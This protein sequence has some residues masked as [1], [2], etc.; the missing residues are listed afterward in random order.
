MDSTLIKEIFGNEELTASQLS[1][2]WRTLAWCESHPDKIARQDSKFLKRD[3]TLG[4][5][6][7]A[8]VQIYGKG[9]D[10]FFKSGRE[11]KNVDI[12]NMVMAIYFERARTTKLEMGR[13]FGKNHSTV[14]HGIR[15]A[16]T[17]AEVD[18]EYKMTFNKLKEQVEICEK[19]F[20]SSSP[21][22]SSRESC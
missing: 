7:A 9:I 2:V 20:T 17:L 15:Q 19:Q 6:D 12:R 11:R 10:F 5:I 21:R 14:I 8:L 4:I 13:I 16:Q 18:K 1:A 22:G 3:K